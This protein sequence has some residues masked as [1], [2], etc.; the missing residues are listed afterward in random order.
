M[1]E[2]T[3][4]VLQRELDLTERAFTLHQRNYY[5]WTQRAWLIDY[6]SVVFANSRVYTQLIDSEDEFTDRWTAT[7]LSDS[8]A[9][10]YR[11]RVLAIRTTTHC[12]HTEMKRVYDLIMRY[13]GHEAIWCHLRLV[14]TS[15]LEIAT[16]EEREE[17]FKSMLDWINALKCELKKQLQVDGATHSTDKLRNELQHQLRHANAYEIW[18]NY[19]NYKL[20]DKT[21]NE[22]SIHIDLGLPLKQPV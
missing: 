21:T 3:H 7:H 9:W 4:A 10:H 15:L 18:I 2:W 20:K 1:I 19:T 17:Q 13:P 11:R 16:V 6:A 12:W 14:A 8:A 22:R 5:A